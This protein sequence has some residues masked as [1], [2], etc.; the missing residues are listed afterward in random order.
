MAD[1]QLALRPAWEG[2][3]DKFAR[4]KTINYQQ[5]VSRRSVYGSLGIGAI[6]LT[7]ILRCHC[8]K[9]ATTILE[10]NAMQHF[11]CK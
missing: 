1:I 2:L 7:S 4:L 3:A 10:I 5:Q 9:W 6:A 8:K 11:H